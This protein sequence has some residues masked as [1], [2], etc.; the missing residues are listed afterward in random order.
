MAKTPKIGINWTTDLDFSGRGGP[1][2]GARGGVRWAVQRGLNPWTGKRMG[3]GGFAA[4][5]ASRKKQIAAAR[6]AQQEA[7]NDPW[8]IKKYVTAYN[9]RRDKDSAAHQAWAKDVRTG[10]E[11]SLGRLYNIGE[12]INKQYATRIREL[13][14]AGPSNAPDVASSSGSGAV[15]DPNAEVTVAQSQAAKDMAGANAAL[16]EMAS[17][18]G[19]QSQKEWITGQLKN[20][21]YMSSRIPAMYNEAKTKYEEG[22]MNAVLDIEGKKAIAQIGADATMYSSQNN[23]LA[24]LASTQSGDQKA[25]LQAL[26]GMY[27]TDQNNQRA[28]QVA[29]LNNASRERISAADNAAA[30]KRVALQANSTGRKFQ[31]E[32]WSN[33]WNGV[34]VDDGAGGKGFYDG[35]DNPLPGSIVAASDILKAPGRI[36]D[37]VTMV[38]SWLD[39]A[40]TN[41]G[42]SPS[43]AA[44]WIENK[45]RGTKAQ[46][47]TIMRRAISSFQ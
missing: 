33:F 23:L 6:A 5:L 44:K 16:A 7:A 41:L 3:A 20:Y 21:D 29:N 17:A 24:S 35:E 13:Q 28:V 12:G 19:Q 18:S 30:L 47:N 15:G 27:N 39:L 10:L 34:A 46:R 11:A 25:L 22:L 45:I 31:N 14:P 4:A 1:G 40:T 36:N 32:M 42:M 26:G 37:K 9:E 8:G 43:Q 2:A 38:Q